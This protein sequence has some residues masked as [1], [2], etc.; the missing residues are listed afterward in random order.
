MPF[1]IHAEVHLID[2]SAFL[3]FLRLSTH[4]QY[5]VFSISCLMTMCVCSLMRKKEPEHKLQFQWI[6]SSFFFKDSVLDSLNCQPPKKQFLVLV[7][8]ST[9]LRFRSFASPQKFIYFMAQEKKSFVAVEK[10]A[11]IVSQNEKLLF[12]P[13]FH[14]TS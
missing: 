3:L 13:V 10:L 4:F 12:S 5:L 8:S 11:S 14:S 2:K 6:F 1:P 7:F 9:S